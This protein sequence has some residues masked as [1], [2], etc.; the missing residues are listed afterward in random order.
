MTFRPYLCPEFHHYICL[1]C[2]CLLLT[3]SIIARM[4]IL[5]EV[6]RRR[7]KSVHRSDLKL[8]HTPLNN[9]LRGF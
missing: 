3:Q 7:P 4:G 1:V 8:V 9:L 5:I 6:F 2:D